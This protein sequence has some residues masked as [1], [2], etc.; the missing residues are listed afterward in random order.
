MLNQYK[1][2]IFIIMSLLSFLMGS[3]S[4][5]EG[6][7]SISAESFR[8]EISQSGVQ[9]L[10]VRTPEEYLEG[11]IGG[12]INIDMQRSNFVESVDGQLD[13]SKPVYLYCRSGGR[14][15]M[16]AKQLAKEGYQVVNLKSGI[17]GWAN[18]GY[19]VV[20]D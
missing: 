6:V 5:Q 4:A 17:I 3:C 13:K 10:D 18:L 16:A 19:P 12:A 11:H 7:R 14:S 15:M 9:L 2:G 8:E 1:I 20:K